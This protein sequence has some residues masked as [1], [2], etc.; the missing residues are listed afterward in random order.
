LERMVELHFKTNDAIKLYDGVRTSPMKLL[1]GP[2]FVEAIDEHSYDIQIRK[3]F[4]EALTRV[5]YGVHDVGLGLEK[6]G[7]YAYRFRVTDFWRVHW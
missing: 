4:I 5:V 7:K 6:I 2:S 3:R 1:C